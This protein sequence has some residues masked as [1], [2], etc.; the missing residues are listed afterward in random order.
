MSIHTFFAVWNFHQ[1]LV[2][3]KNIEEGQVLMVHDYAQNYLC[4]HQHKVQALHWSHSQVTIHPSCILY[5]CPISGCN[6]IVLHKIVHFSD[7]LKHDAH[8]VKKFQQANKECGVP[9]RKIIEFTDQAPSQYKNKS[10]FRYLS[11]ENIPCQRNFFGVRHGKGPCDA[12]AG[13]VKSRLSALMMQKVVI[14]LQRTIWK[15][16]GL[17]NLNACTT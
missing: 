13:R 9:I 8:L 1:Y 4:V 10:A 11:Q 5:R 12:F 7:D 6:Q 14:K 17:T 2:C 15:V 3:K 16:S